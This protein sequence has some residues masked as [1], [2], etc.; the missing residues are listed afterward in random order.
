MLDTVGSPIFFPEYVT[1]TTN[2]DN[3]FD[4]VISSILAEELGSTPA[5]AGIIVERVLSVF[6]DSN[7][8][9][10]IMKKSAS[11]YSL[12]IFN[13]DGKGGSPI[14]TDIPAPPSHFSDQTVAECIVA[15][16]SS[17]DEQGVYVDYPVCQVMC[18]LC[19]GVDPLIILR[20][21]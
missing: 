11:G 7:T 12:A 18:D 10:A 1:N 6:Q 5:V 15:L 4:K 20:D 8:P 3:S 2:N 9:Y 14:V 21:N 17:L 19:A 13:P 16:L